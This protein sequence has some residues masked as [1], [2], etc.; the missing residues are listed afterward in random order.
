MVLKVPQTVPAADVIEEKLPP[1]FKAKLSYDG[2][3]VKVSADISYE[4]EKT[5]LFGLNINTGRCLN[6][7]CFGRCRSS[8][9]I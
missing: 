9:P 5:D 2:D 7:N 8:R 3:G 1:G 4:T 6:R